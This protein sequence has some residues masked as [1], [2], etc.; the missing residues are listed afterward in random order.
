MH[1]A[2]VALLGCGLVAVTT[3]CS[4]PET[5]RAPEPVVSPV[6]STTP[7]NVLLDERFA[8]LPT[9]R[10]LDGE[11]Y[12]AWRAVYDGYGTTT[13][14]DGS[15][16][17]LTLAPRAAGRANTTH[18]AL[19]VSRERFVD[20]DLTTRLWTLRQLRGKPNEW[21][22]PWVLWHYADDRHFY[23]VTLKRNGWELGKED[24]AYPGAQ[25]F[26]RT[27]TRPSFAVGQQHTVRVR[28]VGATMTVWGDGALLTTFTD[29]ERPYGSG[30]VG[31]Y[32][33]DA[34]VAFDR[35]LVRRP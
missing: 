15:Q 32:T 31:L 29:A 7:S 2:A 4:G 8:G 27:G 23:Y 22:V 9:G 10:W 33:E 19:V 20:L 16:P 14:T 26:L 35:V 21:E 28:Q 34:E 13:L 17:Y 11:D 12:G 18:G 25:R 3:C 24:P 6:P 1:R 30:S 5:Q